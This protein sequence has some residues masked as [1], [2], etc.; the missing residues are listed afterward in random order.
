MEHVRRHPLLDSVAGQVVNLTGLMLV[1]L[2]IP[3]FLI[4]ET[5]SQQE[6]MRQAWSIAGPACPV[7]Q[8]SPKSFGD[9]GP[10]SFEYGAVRFDRRYGHASCV[11]PPERGMVSEKTYRVCQF[12]APSTLAVTSGGRTVVY[13]PGTG[14]RATVTVRDGQISCVVGGWFSG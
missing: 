14:R 6:A 4:H 12:S 10:R 8:A 1:I 2:S 11:A 13:K 7:V 3:A 5:W 9:K